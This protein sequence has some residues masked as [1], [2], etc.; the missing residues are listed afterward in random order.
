MQPPSPP[1]TQM[2]KLQHGELQTVLGWFRD[3]YDSGREVF[4][5]DPTRYWRWKDI[6]PSLIKQWDAERKVL[7]NIEED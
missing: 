2:Q 4:P 6:P 5:D 1:Y 3:F 7:E